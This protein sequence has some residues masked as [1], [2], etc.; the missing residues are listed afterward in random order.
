MT[1][2]RYS[3]SLTGLLA[4]VVGCASQPPATSTVSYRPETR[5][6]DLAVEEAD[7]AWASYARERRL[8]ALR[9]WA[10][11][12]DE[13]ASATATYAGRTT[14]R[15]RVAPTP[16]SRASADAAR[17]AAG[18]AGA[19]AE[20]AQNLVDDAM[21]ELDGAGQFSSHHGFFA[22]QVASWYA[23]AL[24]AAERA[25]VAAE[26]DLESADE[27][28]LL[29][30][31]QAAETAR[32]ALQLADEA[33][34]LDDWMAAGELAADHPSHARLSEALERTDRARTLCHG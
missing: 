10:D 20:Q 32:K 1:L 34:D 29:A 15:A 28:A 27:P 7:V 31:R 2:L 4:G 25:A 13:L 8:E 30:G 9:A 19:A 11:G 18:D 26:G 12:A 5:Q 23:E 33:E 14:E 21:G 16:A 3:L 17:Q 6:C 24:R 22:N